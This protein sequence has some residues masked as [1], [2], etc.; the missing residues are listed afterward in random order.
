M[1]SPST[2]LT[3]VHLSR[4]AERA[5]EDWL[6]HNKAFV[7]SNAPGYTDLIAII[8]RTL[9]F[10]IS[11]SQLVAAL[12]VANIY[13]RYLSTLRSKQAK[14]ARTYLRTSRNAV[15][16]AKDLME[17][18]TELNMPI[19]DD[20]RRLATAETDATLENP[21]PRVP[22]RSSPPRP[23]V[24]TEPGNEPLSDAAAALTN[25]MMMDLG[26]PSHNPSSPRP[27]RVI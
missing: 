19:S 26:V 25:Q 18:R 17:I 14:K 23:T 3:R 22:T 21:G 2:G 5:L 1:S 11:K 16:L 8:T 20:L 13:D 15:L 6:I 7:L 4:Q 24:P 12:K 9:H 27:H 10:S